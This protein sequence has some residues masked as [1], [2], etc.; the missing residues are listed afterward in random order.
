MKIKEVERL[1][2]ITAKNIR[3]Y[4]EQ[5]LLSPAR[6]SEN[7]YRNYG[8]SEIKT[9]K[10]IKIL[11]KLDLPVSDIRNVLSGQMPLGT[12]LEMQVLRLSQSIKTLE[13]AKAFCQ[14][15]AETQPDLAKLDVDETLERM[16]NME[17]R[18]S[19]FATIITDFKLA[20]KWAEQVQIVFVPDNIIESPQEFTRELLAYA[21]SQKKD[22]T[23]FKESMYP[24]FV[25]DGIEYEAFRVHGRGPFVICKATHP[26]ELLPY[27][28]PA[29]RVHILAKVW[30]IGI[31]VVVVLLFLLLMIAGR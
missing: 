12:S 14:M 7:S 16:E 29:K 6:N 9:L 10:I 2:G 23:I 19:R 25:Y 21:K 15:M 24:V 31:P 20:V 4:E 30:W 18:G 13:A 8:E 3:F 11:R 22:I 28:V 5:G 1:T 17:A 27:G 26:E